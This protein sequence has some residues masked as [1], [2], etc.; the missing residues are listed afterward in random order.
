[1][2]TNQCSKLFSLEWIHQDTVSKTKISDLHPAPLRRRHQAYT[3][4]R[5]LFPS[6]SG[7]LDINDQKVTEIFYIF[8]AKR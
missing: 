5:S 1:M 8:R 3:R 4:K 6:G 2:K 7:R